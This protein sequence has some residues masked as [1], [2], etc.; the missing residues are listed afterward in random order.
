MWPQT[1]EAACM[2]CFVG[3]FAT[4]AGGVA[5]SLGWQMA[6]C[7]SNA[8]WH[9]PLSISRIPISE[10]VEIQKPLHKIQTSKSHNVNQQ[11]NESGD[12]ETFFHLRNCATFC[13]NSRLFT[14]IKAFVFT[15]IV[16]KCK[17]THALLKYGDGRLHVTQ[18][19]L[20]IRLLIRQHIKHRKSRSSFIHK[21][22]SFL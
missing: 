1:S 5:S 20:F 11:S 14:F 16:W 9:S 2:S 4:A 21:H 15:S 10:A 17:R 22:A 6:A 13:P 3:R 12:V 19:S 8:R 7:C 18:S